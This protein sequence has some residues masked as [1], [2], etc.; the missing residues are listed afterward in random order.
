MMEDA[1]NITLPN[2]DNAGSIGV[3]LY[4]IRL[5][6]I[7]GV[8]SRYWVRTR[9]EF[10]I[11]ARARIADILIVTGHSNTIPTCEIIAIS[12]AGHCGDGVRYDRC[13]LLREQRP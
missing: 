7:L 11:S 2:S 5:G 13:G 4:H 3:E 6:V 1:R 9:L 10:I 8:T 12:V